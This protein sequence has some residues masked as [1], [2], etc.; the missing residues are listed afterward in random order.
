ML[1]EE[2]LVEDYLRFPVCNLGLGDCGSRCFFSCRAFT[3]P[4]FLEGAEHRS[5]GSGGSIGRTGLEV[6][7]RGIVV[8][9]ER[10]SSKS[11]KRFVLS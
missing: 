9:K 2:R 4:T 6:L 7:W 8:R 10:S 3:Q 1:R 5:V 11:I